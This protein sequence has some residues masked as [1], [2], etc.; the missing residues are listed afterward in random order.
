MDVSTFEGDVP[1]T[2]QFSGDNQGGPL[3]E[4][5]WFWSFGDGATSN[6]QNPQHTYTQRGFYPVELS[7]TGEGGDVSNVDGFYL[8]ALEPAPQIQIAASKMEGISPLTVN[9]EGINTG[10]Y[11]SE[12][13]WNWDF[14][15]DEYAAGRIVE[16]RYRKPGQYTVKLRANGPDYYDEKE[17]SIKVKPDITP[18]INLL[19]LD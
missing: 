18:I 4:N 12:N 15:N 14:G 3:G 19:L 16:H 5:P 6:L 1:F 17:I 10:G 11:V 2:V 9:F 7:V 13:D 8:Q